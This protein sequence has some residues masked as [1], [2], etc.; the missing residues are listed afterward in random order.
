MESLFSSFGFR[1]LWTPEL[2]IPLVLVGAL[3]FYVIHKIGNPVSLRQK[4]FFTFGL[5]ALYLGWGSPLYVA[6][7]LMI[8]FHMT[9]M[10]FAYFVATPLLLLGIPTWVYEALLRRLPTS[11]KKSGKVIWNPIIA[12]FLF[13]GLFS[14]YHVPFMFDTLMQSVVLHSLY[15]YLLLFAAALMWW[16][17]L[18]PLPSTVQLSDLRRIGYIF[19]NGILI[20]PACA[21]IIFAGQ[22]LYQTYTD[23]T[24]W[25]TVMSYCL[26][27][28]AEVPMSLF[29]GTN[30]FA[31]LNPQMDQQLAGVL[32]KVMQELMYG[33]TIGYVFKQ[34]LTKEKQ[35]D[36]DLTISDIPTVK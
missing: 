32:M 18:A 33:A 31:F 15:E 14:F 24:I 4:L 10:V 35:Q 17:M 20:T 26:P 30:S 11:I 5:I 22:P 21:L 8:T 13:N 36:G 12:L 19:A 23:P 1:T 7:H 16:H 9:Q 25:E 6:G 34:W 2:I 27:A 28:G 3:Y 29:N